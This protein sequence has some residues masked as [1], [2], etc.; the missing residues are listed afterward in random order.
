M[1]EHSNVLTDTNYNERNV[2]FYVKHSMEQ[3]THTQ[4]QKHTIGI[5]YLAYTLYNSVIHLLR[6]I[7]THIHTQTQRDHQMDG[8]MNGIIL[9]EKANRGI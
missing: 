1:L 2:L 9:I 5:Q 8:K 3:S 7:H 6:V 4:T